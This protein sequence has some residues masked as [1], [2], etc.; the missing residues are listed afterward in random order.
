ML[1]P[2]FKVSIYVDCASGD[3]IVFDDAEKYGAGKAAYD[4]LGGD[5]R[6]V[7][8]DSKDWFIRASCVCVATVEKSTSEVAVEDTV[9]PTEGESE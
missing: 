1:K 5:I 9:C 2:Y 4:Q 8:Y 3:P 7:D 6:I